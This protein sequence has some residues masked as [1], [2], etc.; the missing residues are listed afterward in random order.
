MVLAPLKSI[1]AK[2]GHA[3]PVASFH[4]P[5]LQQLTPARSLSRTAAT[6]RLAL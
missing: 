4:L 1:W 6:G 2:S 5:L 3:L